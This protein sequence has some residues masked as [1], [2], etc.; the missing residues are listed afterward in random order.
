MPLSVQDNA[1]G[2]ESNYS[3]NMLWQTYFIS[4]HPLSYSH[5]KLLG[6]Y[7]GFTFLQKWIM[8]HLYY[9]LHMGLKNCQVGPW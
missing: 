8:F 9:C 2:T 1:L 7:K 3:W 6:P 4:M 5:H